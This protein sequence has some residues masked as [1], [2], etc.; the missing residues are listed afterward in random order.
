MR[1]LKHLFVAAVAATAL[2][3]A[4]ASA[5]IITINSGSWSLGTGWGAAC[6][7]GPCL[8]EGDSNGTGPDD[9]AHTLLNMDWTISGSLAG[10][11]FNLDNLND[12]AT[13]AFGAGYYSDENNTLEP[14]ETNDLAITGILNLSMPSG[15]ENNVG[16]VTPVSGAL[17]DVHNDLSIVFDPITVSFGNG[18]EFTINFSDPS[19]NCNPSQA[20][21]YPSGQTRNINATFTLTKLAEPAK[22]KELATVPEPA[23][24]ALMGIG[25][26]GLSALR[27]SS[28][29]A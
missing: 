23:S 26:A 1:T 7:S 24:W 6:S 25:L 12:S 20:C 4:T 28:K 22:L 8:G 16:T 2:V 27:R 9:G 17:S 3:P 29:S 11:S 15:I 10:T 13:F 18:G 5:V 21:T 19:W 14:T